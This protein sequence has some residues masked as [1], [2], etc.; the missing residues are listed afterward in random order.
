M[1]ATCDVCVGLGFKN[2]SL[3]CSFKQEPKTVD[4]KLS[5]ELRLD[6]GDQKNERCLN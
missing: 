2:S 3:N 6:D 5:Q 4:M 1:R